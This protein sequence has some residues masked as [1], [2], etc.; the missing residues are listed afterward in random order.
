VLSIDVQS[1][2]ENFALGEVMHI[3]PLEYTDKYVPSKYGI[4]FKEKVYVGPEHV[5][6]AF[7]IRLKKDGVE[8]DKH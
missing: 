7:N 1:N 4:L 3:P 6:A 2:K 8:F 5:N